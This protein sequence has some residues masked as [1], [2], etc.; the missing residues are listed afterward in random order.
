[1]S[2]HTETHTQ[3]W[4]GVYETRPSEIKLSIFLHTTTDYPNMLRDKIS[5]IH[6]YNGLMVECSLY[7]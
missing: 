3:Y 2:T 6:F 1:M 7:G 5:F 4:F